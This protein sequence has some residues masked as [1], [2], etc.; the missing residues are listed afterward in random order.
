M[1]HRVH[2]KYISSSHA[3]E[4]IFTPQ[5]IPR[6]LE[7]QLCECPHPFCGCEILR[8]MVFLL[9]IPYL[10]YLT[11]PYFNTVHHGIITRFCSSTGAG[12]RSHSCTRV[13]NFAKSCP[14]A[15]SGLVIVGHILD[16]CLYLRTI[17]RWSSILILYISYYMIIR[18]IY[19]YMY[20]TMYIWLIIYVWIPTEW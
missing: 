3:L 12:F 11:Y 10:T 2:L 1:Q 20:V 17:K 15:S 6:P 7:L 18:Y 13:T 14:P 19:I 4:K 16:R 5:H 8:Q 9:V